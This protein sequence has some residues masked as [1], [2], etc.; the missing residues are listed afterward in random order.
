MM[1]KHR[2]FESTAELR[3]VRVN[4]PL[5]AG[6]FSLHGTAVGVKL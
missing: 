6:H 5:K 2:T 4:V 1:G 3:R